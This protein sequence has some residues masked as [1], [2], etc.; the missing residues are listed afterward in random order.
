MNEDLIKEL[1]DK[2]D[3]L[4]WEEKPKKR[5]SKYIERTTQPSS[6]DESNVQNIYYI[7]F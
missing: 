1:E 3:G 5:K 7:W 4:Y 2:L 6:D